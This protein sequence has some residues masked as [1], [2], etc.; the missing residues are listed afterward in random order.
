MPVDTIVWNNNK[1]RIID[2]TR[3]PEELVYLDIGNIETLGEA[4]RSLRIRGAPAIG[5]AGALGI[6]LAAHNYSGDDTDKLIESIKNAEKYLKKTRPT[7]VNLFWGLKRMI[8]TAAKHSHTSVNHLKRILLN[9]ALAILEED[10]EICRKIGNNGAELLPDKTTVLTHCNAGGLATAD[11]G[12]ALGVVYAAT[13]MGKS[14]KVYADETRPLLQGSRLTAWE[15]QNSGVDVTVLCD[16][17]AGYLM[18]QHKI[19]LIIAGADRIAANG[20]TANK[21]GTFTL[22]VLAKY[23]NIS[24]YIAAPVST[25]DFSLKSGFEIPVEQRGAEEVIKGFKTVTAPAD[26]EVFNPAF[27]ITPSALITAFI[28]EEGVFQAEELEDKLII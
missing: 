5:I 27:D 8:K 7:A 19:D 10:K 26:V 1:I 3:L 11:F 21:I 2:Q 24:F 6:A 25:F 16:S 20:D 9:E 22:A 23:H 17:A 12:T 4:I 13:E 14:V 28:T 15:L 18:Q